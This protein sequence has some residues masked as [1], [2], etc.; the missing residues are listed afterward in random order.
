VPAFTPP[1]PVKVVQ[2]SKK[3]NANL[4]DERKQEDTTTT[5]VPKSVANLLGSSSGARG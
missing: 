3:A 5:A 4:G 1:R 2:N